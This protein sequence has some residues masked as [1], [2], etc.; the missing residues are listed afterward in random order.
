[1]G[2][3]REAKPVHYVGYEENRVAYY[4]GALDFDLAEEVLTNVHIITYDENG[5]WQYI[6]HADRLFYEGVQ[7]WSIKGGFELLSA[8][9]QDR[10]VSQ[11]DVWPSQ[12]HRPTMTTRNLLAGIADDLD[13]FSFAQM[14]QEI[15]TLR[16]DPKPNWRQIRNLE[17]GLYNKIALPLSVVVFALLGAPLGIRSHRAGV[18]SGFA[19]S[20]ALSFAY[21]IIVNFMAV[22]S[23]A[24]QIPPYVASFAPVVLGMVAAAVTIYKKNA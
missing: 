20:I 8:S 7:S 18:A 5:K 21:L 9:G 13:A 1:V 11:E 10:I 14:A 16:R 23:R 2:S 19:L 6:M 4:I 12:V 15:R 24:G 17:F 3:V 22:Y